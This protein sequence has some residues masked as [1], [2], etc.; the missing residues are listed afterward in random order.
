MQAFGFVG[1][2]NLE[3]GFL[4]KYL[5]QVERLFALC[6]HVEDIEVPVVVRNDQR[7]RLIYVSE[8][9]SRYRIDRFDASLF[10][11]NTLI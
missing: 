8:L 9:D 3:I 1:R 7:R 6:V 5:V 11:F 10:Y 2:E 4:F